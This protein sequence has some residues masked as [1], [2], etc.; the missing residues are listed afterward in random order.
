[1]PRTDLANVL[2]SL[3]GF[4]EKKHTK[5]SSKLIR[6]HSGSNTEIS[7]AIEAVQHLVLHILFHNL[8]EN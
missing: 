4:D 7:K 2:Q 3:I 6:I 5:I 1:M 8:L